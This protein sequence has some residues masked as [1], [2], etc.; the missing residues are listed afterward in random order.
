[1]KLPKFSL[2]ASDWKTYTEKDLWEKVLLFLYPKDMTP[3]CTTENQCFRDLKWEFE[4]VWFSIFWLSFDSL[5]RHEKFTEKENLNF[6][7]ISDEEK[8]LISALWAWVEKSMYWRKYMWTD[9]STFVVVNWEIVKEWRK[10]KVKWHVEEVL[11]VCK[12]L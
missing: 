5:K 1:M 2:P 6:P 11:E 9:R 12:G 4:K 8:E 3:W 10:V 7:L